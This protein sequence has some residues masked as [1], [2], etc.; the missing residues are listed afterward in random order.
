M[1]SID[2]VKARLD[3][4]DVVSAY[5]PLKKAG[6][7]YKANC[8]FHAEKTPSFFVFPES[9]SWHCFGACGTG[10]DI[11]SFI[12]RQENLDFG[13]ALALLA[14]KA[15]VTLEPLHPRDVEREH[16]LEKLYDILAAAAA[17]FH[18]MLLHPTMGQGARQY[19]EKRGLNA[20]TVQKF[21][22]GFAPDRW[23]S[24]S[25]HLLQ[26]GYQRHDLLDAGL[27]I[28]RDETS[29]AHSADFY[30]RF[31]GRL[32]VPIRNI[33]GRVVGFGGRIIGEGQ[34]KYLNS[35]QTPLFDKSHI[36]FGIDLAKGAIR[37]RGS[38]IIVEGY[39]DVLQAHQAG[40]GNVVASMGT[41]LTE[42]QI[43]L[44]KRMTQKYILALDPDAAG[45]Q[46]TLRGLS[47]ARQTLDQ[48]MPV[49][50]SRGLIRFENRLGADI[51]IMTLPPGQDPDDLIRDT[52][53]QWPLLVEQ[54][55]PVVDYYFRVSTA[56]LDLQS[57][58]GKAEATRRLVPLLA[59][60]P[61]LVEQNH[62]I[63]KLA[64]LVRMDE[65]PLRRQLQV[66]QQLGARSPAAGPV[67]PMAE[68]DEQPAFTVEEHC[69]TAL[70]RRPELQQ[71]ANALLTQMS[72]EPLQEDDFERTE[73]RALFAAWQSM[74]PTVRWDEWQAQLPPSLQERL[75]LVLEQG[76]DQEELVG[77]EA[78]RDFERNI[79]LRLRAVRIERMVT[80][81]EM[82]QKEA[83]EQGD[84]R[85]MGY[86][87]SVMNLKMARHKL[88]HAREERTSMGKRRQKE[89]S[90]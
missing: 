59:Q 45:D 21:Q 46:G 90:V 19:V 72:L 51:R 74:P 4:V 10:G 87:S 35:P 16:Y 73:N 79:V 11:F 75:H 85:S 49:I 61:N 31:R 40:F 5:V 38:V 23:R 58:K 37:A 18:D 32:I 1:S 42:A 28:A 54:A 25:E 67:E 48:A 41:A 29:A 88:D 52:P 84:A 69:L 68:P 62:Y 76:P 34:P 77:E 3:I 82:V 15:G 44:L 43:N 33:E 71:R 30:D 60:V 55:T 63:Q 2:Q 7:N 36:L 81:L 12:M 78:E 26:R 20:E 47:V 65:Q 17:F 14:Q 24:V 22:L 6:R 50:D 9:Q 89:Q 57:A 13:A 27:I 53:E 56:D 8:P 70:F 86:S 83:M 80:N 64:R 39:M 66:F